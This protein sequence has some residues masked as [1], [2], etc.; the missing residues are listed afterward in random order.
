MQLHGRNNDV[1]D[2]TTDGYSLN[3][4][5]NETF[6]ANAARVAKRSFTIAASDAGPTADEYTL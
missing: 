3:E 1:Q 5:R 2:V 6:A 4:G